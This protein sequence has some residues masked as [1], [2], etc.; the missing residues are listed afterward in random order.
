M[1]ERTALVT[2]GSRGIGR[3]ISLALASRGFAVAVN[4]RTHPDEAK[5]T[6]QQIERSGGEGIVVEADVRD[7]GEVEAMFARVEDACGHV[8]VLVNNAGVRTD[9][10]GA[11]MTLAQWSDVVDT[12]LT[13][14]FVCTRRALR[15]MIRER[16]GRVVNVASV[17]AVRGSPGQAN[18]SAAK[19]GM[20]GLTRTLAREVARK[21]VTI[22]AI[23]PGLI[24]T[25]LTDSLSAD[26]RQRLL[27]E[28]PM[29][30][31]GRAD[32]IAELAAFLSSDEAAYITGAVV[33]A[34]GG[35]TA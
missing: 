2:G 17:A 19:A 24:Q 20:V 28:I 23:A 12:N 3:A 32:E 15:A 18:Y 16:W 25:D 11:R 33:V 6:L 7:A 5:E 30:R 8:A 21:N 10:L 13:G 4:Y 9:A 14:A 29:G 27:D 34:D 22:N 35:M 31:A 26:Q 1:P